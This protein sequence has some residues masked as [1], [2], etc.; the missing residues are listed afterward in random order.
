M[1]LKGTLAECRSLPT[2]LPRLTL[3]LYELSSP[4]DGESTE[5][6][7]EKLRIESPRYL[8]MAYN[9]LSDVNMAQMVIALRT[10][11]YWRA[12]ASKTR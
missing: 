7:M 12:R 5:Q 3:M 2:S 8:A 4:G 10:L 6:Q 9:G 11:G 1:L